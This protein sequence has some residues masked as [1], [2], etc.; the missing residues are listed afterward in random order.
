MAFSF[1]CGLGARK[2][3]CAM[4]CNSLTF[5]QAILNIYPRLRSVIGYNLWTLTKDKTF[6][7]IPE[8]VNTPSRMRSY[9]G[10]HFTGCLIIVPVSD[11]VLMEER[12]E[13]LRQRDIKDDKSMNAPTGY[14]KH[15]ILES[16]VSQVVTEKQE[17]QHSQTHRSLCLIC[18]RIEK[19]AGT[20]SFHKI[21]EEK[22]QVGHERQ[23]I[24]KKLTDILGFNFEQSKRKFIASSEI[25]KRCMRTV[26]DLVKME[27]QLKST[28]EELVSSFFSTT[29]K[30]NKNH[31][32]VDESKTSPNYSQTQ[33]HQNGGF[34]T[35]PVTNGYSHPFIQRPLPLQMA[36][37]NQQS[38]MDNQIPVTTAY[39]PGLIQFYPRP[40]YPLNQYGEGR[41]P[42]PDSKS[43]SPTSRKDTRNGSD[44]GGSEI[45]SSSFLSVSPTP[46]ADYLET[47]SLPGNISPRPF[48][49]RSYASTFSFHS[50]TS[51]IKSKGQ[52][53]EYE[54]RAEE[55]IEGDQP[56]DAPENFSL[57]KGDSRDQD[58]SPGSQGETS[59]RRFGSPSSMESNTPPGS[60]SPCPG[61]RNLDRKEEEER[62][63]M[64][65][66]WKKRKRI[67]ESDQENSLELKKTKEDSSESNDSHEQLDKPAE[68]EQN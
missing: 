3:Q 43:S 45:G 26:T 5:K 57:P 54:A 66:P 25:C 9:L 63:E 20:G 48:D 2:W 30:F 68:F 12:R 21:H 41:D 44:Y 38:K 1:F 36:L 14:L 23:T 46:R 39:G 4:D 52:I 19:T 13:H 28:K 34:N 40:N 33:T 6:E 22:I 55:R 16:K 65:K 67:Q 47:E 61:E 29:S 35:S 32:E 31:R 56:S 15:D 62:E 7:R 53:K 37:F 11:I 18:G 59:P 27:D 8:K 10:P 49:T 17:T 24:S 64:R 58:A 51:S 50:S 60:S 42:E